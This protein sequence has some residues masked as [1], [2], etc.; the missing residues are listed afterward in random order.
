ISLRRRDAAARRI[1][2]AA[3]SP[4][5]SSGQPSPEPATLAVGLSPP[6]EDAPVALGVM[7]FKPLG[8]SPENDWKR[9]ALRDAI[10]TELTQ[11]SRVKIYSKEFID[12]LIAKKNLTEIEAASQLGIKKML[13]GSFSVTGN[14]LRIETHVV[15]VETGV[16]Q[17]SYTTLGHVN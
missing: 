17:G 3:K 7:L 10:N 16:L 14:A 2:A 1:A 15:D 9:E 13:S 8:T 12:F 6:G 5:E 4:H 11:L